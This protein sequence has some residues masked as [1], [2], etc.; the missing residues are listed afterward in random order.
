M[1][2]A[3]RKPN[4]ALAWVERGLAIEKR[5]AFGGGATYKLGAMR[6][7]LLVKLGRGGE[8]LDS[9]WAQF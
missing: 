1:F 3:R 6:R 8:A 4:D 9:A 5:N 7:A 2:Q